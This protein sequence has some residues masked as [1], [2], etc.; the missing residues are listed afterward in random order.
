MNSM[1]Q[2]LL[3]TGGTGLIGSTLARRLLKADD[4]RITILSRNPDKH[5][6]D[7]PEQIDWLED[8]DE[9]EPDAHFDVVVNLAGEGI[10]DKRWSEKQKLKIYHS[11]IDL[12]KKLVSKLGELPRPPQVMINGSAIGYYGSQDETL[13]TEDAAPQ[14]EFTHELCRDWEM[15]AQQIE[16]LGT[17]LCCIR[18]AVV[19]DKDRGALPQMLLP[20]RLFVGGKIGNGQQ[21]MSWIHLQD[22]V[23]AIE[24]LLHNDKCSGAYNL[25]SPNAVNN[26]TFSKTVGKVMH[27]PSLFPLPALVVKIMFGEMGETLLLSG[28]HVYP[29]RLLQ[30]GFKFQYENLH[31]ALSSLL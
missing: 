26:A 4:Y 10:G 24:F 9:I 8:I 7:L 12:T 1:K 23:S 20:F 19:L 17:R 3:I 27:R 25:S 28:Q 15:A 21:Y 31:D 2:K 16:T 29:E 5:R 30:A 13:L 18:T 11:R 14:Q 22:E 6:K